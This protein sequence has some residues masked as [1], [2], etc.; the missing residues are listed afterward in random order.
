MVKLLLPKGPVNNS[1]PSIFLINYRSF[2]EI[3]NWKC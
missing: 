2:Q 3:R 1:T